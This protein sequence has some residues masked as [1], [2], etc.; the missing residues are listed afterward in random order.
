MISDEDLTMIEIITEFVKN[1]LGEKLEEVILFGSRARGDYTED[2][3]FDIAVIADFDVEMDI[4]DRFMWVKKG[5]PNINKTIE[6][7]PLTR[8]EY[9]NKFLF[10]PAIKNEGVVLY[11]R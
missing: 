7:I 10:T 3:D 6:F 2:S 1:K 4:V 11:A 8:Y 9:E 5:K